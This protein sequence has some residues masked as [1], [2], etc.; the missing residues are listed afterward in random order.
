MSASRGQSPST[1]SASSGRRSPGGV[2]ARVRRPGVGENPR[3]RRRATA[4]RSARR[5]TSRAS[6]GAGRKQPLRPDDQYREHGGENERI[7]VWPQIERQ[8]RLEG[9]TVRAPI[10]KPPSDGAGEAPHP[11]DDRRHEGDQDDVDAD[12]RRHGAG[13][14][15]EQDRRGGGEQPR[16][17]ERGGDS[18]CWPESRARGPSGSPRPRRASA[19]PASSAGRRARRPRAGRA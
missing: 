3:A 12:G 15:R 10:E 1:S 5:G 11:A 18:R 4:L 16:E 6:I 2:S 19:C 14:S 17:R 8:R 7:A 13:L 9:T